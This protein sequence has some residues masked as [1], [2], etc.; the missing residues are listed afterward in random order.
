MTAYNKNNRYN[1][2]YEINTN[3]LN[4]MQKNIHNIPEADWP[5]RKDG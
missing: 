5:G 3:I 4:Y 1:I 2:K